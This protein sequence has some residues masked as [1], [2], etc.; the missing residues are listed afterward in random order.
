MKDVF[1]LCGVTAVD[2]LVVWMRINGVVGLSAVCDALIHLCTI[3]CAII[4]VGW[5]VIC[6]YALYSC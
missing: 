3:K 1:I 4:T 5:C 6:C 2:F